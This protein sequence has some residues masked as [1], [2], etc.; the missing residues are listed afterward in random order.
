M[1]TLKETANRE[2]EIKPNNQYRSVAIT[3]TTT[4]GKMLL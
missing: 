3:T 4:T 1:K 2:K